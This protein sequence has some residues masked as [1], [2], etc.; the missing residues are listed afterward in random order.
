MR[1]KVPGH[2]NSV[3]SLAVSPCGRYLASSSSDN[4]VRI[5]DAETGIELR[6]IKAHKKCV[7][8]VAY[9]KEAK[10]VSASKDG[11]VKLLNLASKKKEAMELGE[12]HAHAAEVGAVAISADG[13][14]VVSGGYDTSV[15]VWDRGTGNHKI[16]LDN[17]DT[18]KEGHTDKVTCVA[19][20]K[21]GKSIISGSLD[22]TARIWQLAEEE[23]TDSLKK[24][25]VTEVN[26]R[27]DVHAVT[28]ASDEKSFFAGGY[29]IIVQYAMVP[30][31]GNFKIEGK[32]HVYNLGEEMKV[33]KGHASTVR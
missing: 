20:S 6:E 24:V 10:I 30:Q 14:T 26:F 18:K 13:E 19:V 32:K 33:F 21:N 9:L 27:S 2:L 22:Q 7:Y 25:K 1:K 31:A 11:T 15:S 29:C 23:E 8:G 17:Y 4:T 28:F 3:H 12:P 5:W 16:T